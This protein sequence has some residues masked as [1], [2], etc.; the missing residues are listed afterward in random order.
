MAETRRSQTRR[1]VLGYDHLK[2]LTNWHPLL[3]KDYQ[4]ILQDF[5]FLADSEDDLE[6]RIDGLQERIEVLEFK[7][8]ETINTTTSLTTSGY[9]IIICKN[10]LPITI[11]L[12]VSPQDETE[13]HI[14]RSGVA[15]KVI[16]QVDGK[17]NLKMNAPL[18]SLHLVFNGTDWSQI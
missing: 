13:V 17:T 11:E 4:G 3:I 16:G 1:G 9:Q 2:K 10:T 8:F 15:F 18:F 12:E 14:K 6:L 7:A 5:A